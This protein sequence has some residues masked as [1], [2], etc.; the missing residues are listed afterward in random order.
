M[1]GEL[2]QKIKLFKQTEDEL[3]NDVA[4]A[5]GVRFEDAMAPVAC[6]HPQMDLSPFTESKQV[7]D[8]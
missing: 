2:A 7:I 5:Y 8:G 6:M 3:T 4:D 1:E